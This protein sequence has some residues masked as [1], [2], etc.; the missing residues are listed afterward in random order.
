MAALYVAVVLATL[1]G[2]WL[3]G[4]GRATT[5]L[6]E[7]RIDQLTVERDSAQLA[8]IRARQTVVRDTVVVRETIT[9][10]KDKAAAVSTVP[11]LD[12][13]AVR[14]LVSAGNDLASKCAQFLEHTETLVTSADTL[15][16]AS[17]ALITTIDRRRPSRVGQIAKVTVAVLAGIGLG[18][19]LF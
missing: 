18:G 8:Y 4:R 17:S 13:P 16:R 9:R 7:Q 19:I 12:T 5:A 2:I 3:Y 6:L 10:W 11:E 14:A 15:N 1:G